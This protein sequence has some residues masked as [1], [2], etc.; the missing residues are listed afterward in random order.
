MSDRNPA[1]Q[2]DLLNALREVDETIASI[3]MQFPISQIAS[4]WAD[5]LDWLLD[6]V[7]T[8]EQWQRRQETFR[9]KFGERWQAVSS[10]AL[11]PDPRLVS[12]QILESGSYDPLDGARPWGGELTRAC[13]AAFAELDTVGDE[14]T[15]VFALDE[16][17]RAFVRAV[18]AQAGKLVL[19][20]LSYAPLLDS[21]WQTIL[22][23][24]NEVIQLALLF[25][26][27]AVVWLI[28]GFYRDVNGR[29]TLH[30][31]L[32][33]APP[34]SGTRVKPVHVLLGTAYEEQC[35]SLIP[36][37][38]AARGTRTRPS[39]ALI[40]E[41]PWHRVVVQ[42]DVA[43]DDYELLNLSRLS[44]NERDMGRKVMYM[45]QDG[46]LPPVLTGVVDDV[47]RPWQYTEETATGGPLSQP[48]ATTRELPPLPATEAASSSP[49]SAPVV[50]PPRTPNLRKDAEELRRKG[51]AIVATSPAVAQ[52]YL[53]AST[54][55]D[56]TSVDVWLKLVDLA[57][58]P[59]Q[60]EAFRREAEKALR[61]QRGDQ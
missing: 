11:N 53:L 4:P 50:R 5:V 56:N 38:R 22:D 14:A 28:G 45:E 37:V 42:L 15:R 18:H 23:R 12:D 48:Q 25:E 33:L 13:R 3:S 51:M 7:S 58:S 43:T 49:P 10:R 19:P 16:R 39:D 29:L 55:L 47:P 17:T 54:V 1:S 41:S 57:S 46:R 8:E 20:A 36:I 21:E 26:G 24:L 30:P 59:R 44:D 34:S 60:K 31:Q 2:T 52:K 9:L 61:R 35:P 32:S 40:A 6:D 27:A